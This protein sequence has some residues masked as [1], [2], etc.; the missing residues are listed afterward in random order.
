MTCEKCTATGRFTVRIALQVSD[1]W[2]TLWPFRQ[3][4]CKRE[5]LVWKTSTFCKTCVYFSGQ[6]YIFRYEKDSS[7]SVPTNDD[8]DGRHGIPI[9]A[10]CVQRPDLARSAAFERPSLSSACLPEFRSYVRSSSVAYFDS[11]VRRE[12]LLQVC[13]RGN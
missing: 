8:L 11:H 5:L 9:K 12:G 2:Q 7:T 10:C 13:T 3:E 4:F 1:C 6:L